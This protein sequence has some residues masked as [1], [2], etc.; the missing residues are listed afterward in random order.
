[1]TTNTNDYQK[2]YMKNYVKNSI[3]IKCFICLTNYKK[4]YNYR[5]LKSKRHLKNLSFNNGFI[6]V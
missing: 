5:H 2:T 1:M 6:I 4:V 3:N